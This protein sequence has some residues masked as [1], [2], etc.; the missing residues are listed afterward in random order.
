MTA[1]LV[2]V[3]NVIVDL[4]VTIDE[5]PE[6][7][8]DAVGTSTGAAPGGSFNTM[9][10]AAR[11]GL[12]T[13][14]GGAHGTG[15][16]GDLVR[17]ALAAEQIRAIDDRTPGVDTGFDV[18][19][20]DSGGERTFVTVFGA[21]ARLTATALDRIRLTNDDFVHVSG[22][23]LLERTNTGVLAPWLDTIGPGP[24]VLFDPGPLVRDI[25]EAALTAVARRAD[26]LSCSLREAQLMTG[27]ED[28]G[29]AVSALLERFAR[30]VVRLGA[31]G[32]LVAT[33]GGRTMVPGFPVA[34]VDTNGAGDA[35]AGAFLAALA[36]GESAERAALVGNAAAG[37]AVTRRGPATAP[38]LDE[39]ATMLP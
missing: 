25:P 10:A 27:V 22:Y 35:H 2:S 17:D 15:A 14:Y 9:V 6:R 3:G 28:V 29:A 5:L 26:W 11:Q 32:C 36:R 34:V 19:M 37:L 39:L 20:T 21:E 24:V 23:G 33:P 30:V 16:F 1:R 13:E 7:G 8:G 31:E 12:T 4:T 18:A 38:R